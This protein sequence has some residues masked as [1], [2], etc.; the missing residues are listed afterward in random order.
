M[1]FKIKFSSRNKS[2]AMEHKTQSSQKSQPNTAT[3]P[4]LGEVAFVVAATTNY[5]R[6]VTIIQLKI[7]LLPLLQPPIT[8]Y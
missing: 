8:L 4:I 1:N 7:T 3:S 6:V 5:I 2:R